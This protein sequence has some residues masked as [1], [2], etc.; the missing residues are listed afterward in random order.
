MN[1]R[2]RLVSKAD[3]GWLD[4]GFHSRG[5][6]KA[7]ALELGKRQTPLL[8]A[9]LFPPRIPFTWVTISQAQVC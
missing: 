7:I 4:W 5:I 8:E 3:W 6:G 2:C 9:P 1:A